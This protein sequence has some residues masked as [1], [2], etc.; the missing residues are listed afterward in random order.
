MKTWRLDKNK[1]RRF[2]LGN[3]WAFSN[4]IQGSPKGVEAGEIVELAD[5]GGAFLAFGFA[6][7]ASLISFR[8]I[9]RNPEW[10]EAG[11]VERA[12]DKARDLRKSLGVSDASHR[13]VYAEVDGIPGLVVDA[14]LANESDWIFVLQAQTAGADKILDQACEYYKK[15][16]SVLVKNGSEI[17]KLEGLVPQAPSI[18]ESKNSINF[19][20]VSVAIKT[21]ATRFKLRADLLGGQKTGLF[22]DQ[23]TNI[24][25]L[26]SILAGTKQK[27]LK[28]LDLCCYVGQWS[29]AIATHAKARNVTMHSTLLDTS[30]TALDHAHHNVKQAGTDVIECITGDVVKDL[31]DI[32]EQFDVVICDPPAFIAGRKNIPVGMK[33]YQKLNEQALGL[34]KPGG[35]LVTCSCSG[36]VSTDEFEEVITKAVSRTKRKFLAVYRGGQAIDHPT[37]PGF[38]EGKYLKTWIGI[39][40]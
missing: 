23:R 21:G 24:E 3:P 12:L 18:F 14:Y 29:T 16:G 19:N 39:V 15:L 33:A 32:G 20:E 31:G 7:S 2:R 4:E 27:T 5:S 1:D 40:E 26:L 34:V 17:R 38:P 6:N 37:L 13:A 10:T 35:I 11:W 30:K 28:V 9:S 22:L 36:L 25:M 8:E